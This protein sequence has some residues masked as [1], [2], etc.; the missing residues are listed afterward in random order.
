MT[1]KAFGRVALKIKIISITLV[2]CFQWLLVSCYQLCSM[3]N[4]F[5]SQITNGTYGRTTVIGL[6]HNVIA[7]NAALLCIPFRI[8]SVKDVSPTIWSHFK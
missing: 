2:E 4:Q 6:K 1:K 8:S 5:A 3:S 7:R